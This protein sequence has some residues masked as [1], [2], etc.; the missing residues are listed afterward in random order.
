MEG[1][2]EM[3]VSD[4]EDEPPRKKLRS[5]NEIIEDN[6]KLQ[7]LK[8]EADSLRCQLEAYKNEVCKK[9]NKIKTMINNQNNDVEC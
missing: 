2:G 4:S 5:Q 8:D 9:K 7:A 6:E 3:E 1:E